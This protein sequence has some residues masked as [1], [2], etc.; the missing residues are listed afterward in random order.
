MQYLHTGNSSP[1]PRHS[2][3]SIRRAFHPRSYHPPICDSVRA[4]LAT[5]RLHRVGLGHQGRGEVGQMDLAGCRRSRWCQSR[6]G[7]LGRCQGKLVSLRLYPLL[8]KA[9]DISLMAAASEYVLLALLFSS[10]RT[11][12]TLPTTALPKPTG[13]IVML[14][15]C[16]VLHPLAIL[17]GVAWQRTREREGRIRLTEEVEE[18]EAEAEAARHGDRVHAHAARTSRA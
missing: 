12:P 10:P 5:Q 6:H 13:L 2:P 1:L 16:L 8:S 3:S 15:V 9:D 11:N 17:A 7:H 18:A 4:R 14:I